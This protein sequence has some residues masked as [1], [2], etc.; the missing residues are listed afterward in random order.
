METAANRGLILVGADLNKPRMVVENEKVKKY[1]SGFNFCGKNS[2]ITS[3]Q[4]Y[5]MT[6]D[7]NSYLTKIEI[8]SNYPYEMPSVFLPQT[9]VSSNCPHRYTNGSLCIMRS[10]DWTSI[11]SIA[12]VIAKSAI[13]LNKYDIWKRKGTWM[14]KEQKH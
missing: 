7:G 1:F 12:F 2:E 4:G 10:E 13:W 3:V 11:Y 6:A 14:G 5:L 8:S 9:V